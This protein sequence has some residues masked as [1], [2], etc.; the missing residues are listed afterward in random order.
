MP[1]R[2]PGPV[3]AAPRCP[4]MSVGAAS[5]LAA[6]VAALPGAD[7]GLHSKACSSGRSTAALHL[8]WPCSSL[9]WP[10]RSPAVPWHEQAAS[11]RSTGRCVQARRQET[12]TAME[13]QFRESMAGPEWELEDY[14]W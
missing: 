9:Q 1:A 10:N 6:P 8:T 12:Q 5:G 11:Y 4:D 14:E 7:T 2:P 13:H 3:S